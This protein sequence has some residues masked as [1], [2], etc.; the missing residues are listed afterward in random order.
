M[1]EGGFASFFREQ[2]GGTVVLL[3]SMGASLADAEDVA[4]EVMTEA[5]QKWET[6]TNP[7]AWVHTVAA[8]TFWKRTRQKRTVPL[9]E[10]AAAEPAANDTDLAPFTEEQCNVLSW[11]RGLPEVQRTVFALYYDGWSCEEIAVLLGMEPSTVR[12]NLRHARKALKKVIAS[13]L[14]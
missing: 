8:R 12:S 6:L 4:Q 3:I 5:W 9:D 7:P 11:L 13:E 1:T 2:F 10:D 14:H